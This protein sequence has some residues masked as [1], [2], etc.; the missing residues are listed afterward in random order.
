MKTGS[1]KTS[2]EGKESCP[3][4]SGDAGHKM[5]G[6]KHDMK[7]SGESCP[8]MKDGKPHDMHSGMKTAEGKSGH[9]CSCCSGKENKDTTAKG[10]I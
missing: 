6:M 1:A 8:M 5:E 2:A 3:M 7:M 10:A 4:M 9:S